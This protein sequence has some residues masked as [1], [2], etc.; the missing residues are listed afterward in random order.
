MKRLFGVTHIRRGARCYG[1]HLGRWAEPDGI[2]DAASPEAAASSFSRYH[3]PA[4][5]VFVVAAGAHESP[6]SPPW[7]RLM[8][9]PSR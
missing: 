7:R 2:F 1:R 5:A 4:A 3:A 9:R 6:V 8:P